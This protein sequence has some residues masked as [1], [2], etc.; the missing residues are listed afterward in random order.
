MATSAITGAEGKPIEPLVNRKAWKSLR[1][2]YENIRGL[3]LR[4]LFAD[5]PK[6]GEQMTTE[7]VGLVLDYSKN[8][9]NA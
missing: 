9:I 3:H 4:K 2:H 7:G 5:N 6:R 8:R 1:A